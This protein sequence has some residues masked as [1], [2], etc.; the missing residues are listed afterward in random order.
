MHRQWFSKFWCL[1]E[2]SG[3]VC[4]FSSFNILNFHSQLGFVLKERRNPN[5]GDSSGQL[6]AKIWLRFGFC[7]SDLHPADGNCHQLCIDGVI[8]LITGP[9]IY[10]EDL[11]TLWQETVLHFVAEMGQG[12]ESGSIKS[13]HLNGWVCKCMCAGYHLLTLMKCHVQSIT[14]SNTI[15]RPTSIVDCTAT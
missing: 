14:K 1:L 5:S 12:A 2:I 8:M 11:S 3:H 4:D 6:Q 15:T 10:N 7:L 13:S 9:Q